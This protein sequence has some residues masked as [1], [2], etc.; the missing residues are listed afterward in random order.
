MLE[1][2][3][4]LVYLTS[5]HRLGKLTQMAKYGVCSTLATTI[6][7]TLSRDWLLFSTSPF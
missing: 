1:R 6:V 5:L 2:L 4:L 7:Q 3:L